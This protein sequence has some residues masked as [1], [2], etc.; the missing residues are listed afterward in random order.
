[1]EKLSDL[2]S[3][4]V[5]PKVNGGHGDEHDIAQGDKDEKHS[6][7][8]AGYGTQVYNIE[9]TVSHGTGTEKEG[10]DVSQIKLFLGVARVAI[11]SATID[12]NRG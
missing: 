12:N 5:L 11:G 4:E 7:L 1:M 10:V 2:L 8:E 9:A 6:L 3:E